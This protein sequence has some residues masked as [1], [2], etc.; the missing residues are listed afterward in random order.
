MNWI[1]ALL[2]LAASVY[3]VLTLASTVKRSNDAAAKQFRRK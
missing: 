2:T 1:P 3:L